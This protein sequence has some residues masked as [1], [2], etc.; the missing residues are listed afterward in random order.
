MRR[1]FVALSVVA[2]LHATTFG[3]LFTAL[4]NHSVTK[5]DELQVKNAKIGKEMV[6]SKLY[7]KINLYA[8]Y[9]HFSDPTGMV[10]VPPN[11]L[12]SMV[13]DPSV[14][15]PFSRNVLREGASFTMPIF[16]KSIYT[17]GDKASMMQ[18][19]AKAK[20]RVNLIKNEAVIVGANANL[21]Y[22]S[23]LERS[24]QT[25]ERS[26]KETEKT[27]KIKVES[28]RSPESALYKIDD[29]L[30]QINIA[31]NNIA[32]QKEQI[33]ASIQALT[34]IR[35]Q[36]AIAMGDAQTAIDTHKIGSLEPLEMKLQ[37]QKA[38]MDSAKEKLYPSLVAYGNYSFSQAKAY[39]N[40]KSVNEHYG[41]I[42]VVLNLPL[43][44]DTYTQYQQ[45]KVQLQKEE[46][47]LAKTKE[48][49]EA[50]AKALQDSLPLLNRSIE[51]AKKSVANKEKLLN[52]AKVNYNSG[53]LST[54]EYLRY[55]DDVVSAKAALYKAKAAKWQNLLQLAVIYGNNIEEIVK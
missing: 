26:L 7:P 20:K 32:L 39:N 18:K 55:E 25:K 27:L 29:A 2:S 24:L 15:Q 22:L 46:A 8:K 17:L 23:Q 9:D 16:V 51:L 5:A 43:A 50:K 44:F 53:R 35:L 30:N 11:T 1:I 47:D 10:P 45:E 42:G 34:G 19:S 49:L 41:N 21:L 28:G 6:N 33:V 12:L 40:D 52:I 38:Q 3:E 13:K 36:E 14:A 4:K 31:K 54:E 48:A 37:A